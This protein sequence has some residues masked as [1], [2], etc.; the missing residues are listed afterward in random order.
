MSPKLTS[1]H[2]PK[3]GL[4]ALLAST[5]L[6]AGCSTLHNPWHKAEAP[7][8]GTTAV[9]SSA[10]AGSG[11][12]EDGPTPTITAN[13]PELP[14]EGT[15]V[16]A[17]EPTAVVN[18]SAPRSYTVQR[19][20]TL[21][22]LAN[23]F[24]RDPWLWPE[25]WYVNPQI[26]NPHLIYPGDVLTLVQGRDGSVSQIQLRRGP[27][28]RLSPMLRNSG[29][30]AD[31]SVATVPY[32]AIRAF[33][34][35]PGIITSDEIKSAPYVL[36]IRD[37]HLVGG[38]NNDVY[39]KGPVR[40]VGE[41]YNVM[42]I[43]QPLKGG[44]SRKKVGYMTVYSGGVQLSRGGEPA[45]A[46]VTESVRE[47]QIGDVLLPNTPTDT[48]AIVPHAPNNGL[49]TRVIAVTDGV[50]LAG[51]YQV[52]ALSAGAAQ[53]VEVGHVL[54]AWS[55][56]QSASDRCKRVNGQYSCNRWRQTKLPAE[57][58]GTMLVF[59]VLDQVSYALIVDVD[60]PVR[61]NDWV[62]KP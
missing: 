61:V 40:G 8:A 41:R 9:A 57:S 10:A 13:L 25:I 31:G 35:R 53:G 38:L 29:V 33:L 43:E 2:C 14:P 3:A 27:V 30:N 34:S 26:N 55:A 58:A 36:S 23:M 62:S 6:A 4:I 47:I 48:A 44:N 39:V 18:G 12:A 19:G 51:N 15:E 52:V 28:T 11:S 45:T 32:E 59:K 17:T 7:A 20:D 49:E 46:R 24:L 56:A 37:G 21:W 16:V 22:G 1:I 54:R 60:V 5:A 50:K 42:H